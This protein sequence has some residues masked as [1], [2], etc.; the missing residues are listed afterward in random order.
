MPTVSIVLPTYNGEKYIRK[1]I[2]SVIN[3]TYLDWELIIVDDCSTDKTSHIAEEYANR[4]ERIKVIHNSNN[5][6]LPKSLNIG[7]QHARGEYFTWTS[8]DNIYFPQAIEK[9]V[10]KISQ[11]TNVGLVCADMVIIDENDNETEVVETC[12]IDL[13]IS[14]CIGACFLYKRNVIEIIG[15]YDTSLFLVEDYDYWLRIEEKIGRINHINEVLYKYRRHVDSL[16][17][18]RINQVI[19]S[20]MKLREKHRKYILNKLGNCHS[21]LYYLF[22]DNY[23]NGYALTSLNKSIADKYSELKPLLKQKRKYE[24]VVV[25]GAG[26]YGNRYINETTKKIL[27][28]VDNNPNKIGTMIGKYQVMPIEK[29]KFIDEDVCVVVAVSHEKKSEILKQLEKIKCTNIDLYK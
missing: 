16:S 23:V 26:D 14:N 1:S 9:L 18:K 10:N 28:V 4:D 15:E 6:K 5:L 8:D 12:A 24:R 29:I 19:E 21:G 22:F 25:F 3:Q 7:F 27:F 20:K 17:E 13:C 11:D 2:D